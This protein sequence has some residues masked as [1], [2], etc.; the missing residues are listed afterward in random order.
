MAADPPV[1]KDGKC[2][3][4][5]KRRKLPAKSYASREQHERDPFWRNASLEVQRGQFA[6]I[7]ARHHSEPWHRKW[8]LCS[9]C[10]NS[11]RKWTESR[12]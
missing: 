7:S 4:C 11:L 6:S 2:A 9:Y 10:F 8:H 12:A 1:R 3:H 5:G